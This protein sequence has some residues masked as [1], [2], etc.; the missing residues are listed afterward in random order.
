MATPIPD[1]LNPLARKTLRRLNEA[2]EGG[3]TG[4][5][6]EIV[7]T[8]R[9]LSGQ[10]ATVSIQDL[11]EIIE[12]D[13]SVTEKVISAANTFGYNPSGIEIGTI[14]EAIHTV[15]FD[16][17]RNLTLTVMLAQNAGKGMDSEQQREM[18]SL[19]V[20]SGL[21]AQN[22]VSSSE[23][24]S[25]DPDIAF[26]SGSLRNYGKLL[27]STFFLDEYT[28]ARELARQGAN[29]EAYYDAFG[30]TPLELGHTLLLST[31]LPDI[32]MESLERV[33]KEKLTRSAQSDSE[34]VLIAAE[35]CVQVCELAFNDS[36]GPD[37]FKKE[38]AAIVQRF[39][40]S[41][42][43]DLDM[44]TAGLEEVDSSMAQLNE[45]IGIK[46]SPA[47][48]AL[49]ARLD[50]RPLSK[51]AT[52]KETRKSIGI[53][54]PNTEP[55]RDLS[56]ILESMLESEEPLD[57]EQVKLLYDSLN[58]AIA[59]ELGLDCCMTFLE[60]QENSRT[61]RFSAR[62]GTG[63]L[64][65]RIKTRPLVSSDNKDIFSIC[66]ARGE[67]ILIQDANSGKIAKVIPD[68]IHDR[69]E[70]NSLILL[71]ASLDK[72]LFALF[73]GVKMDGT[74]IEIEPATHQ[75]FRQLRTQLA[76]M[77]SRR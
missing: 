76:K 7:Q 67:D 2:I 20:C 50:G 77:Q 3:Q 42:P 17:I 68:W 63:L 64:Y 11:S 14:T 58:L 45:V 23:L 54:K 18:A 59:A 15:G 38:L 30:M 46:N 19:S 48:N 51:P 26:V 40:D 35:F 72:K 21:L 47:N 56:E 12:R 22:L 61:V 71:P 41:I 1:T 27:M 73:V 60:D 25:C 28:Q 24:F 13:P 9:K 75:R 33:P 31:N 36:L 16:R 49:R 6:P 57:D 65:D 43:I 4:A 69:G 55:E 62:N 32:I 10:I 34:E 8:V 70:V 39:G 52:K 37:A 29:D 44:V 53:G 5:M 74:P 66:L